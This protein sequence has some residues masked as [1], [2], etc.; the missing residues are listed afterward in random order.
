MK[1]TGR[2]LQVDKGQSAVAPQK[3]QCPGPRNRG[4]RR[5]MLD[6]QHGCRG[7]GDGNRRGPLARGLQTEAGA[8]P[9][10]AIRPAKRRAP[11]REPSACTEAVR[12]DPQPMATEMQRGW[13]IR[14]PVPAH[15]SVGE[16]G[17]GRVIRSWPVGC[18][19]GSSP[20]GAVLAGV[21]LRIRS[22]ALTFSKGMYGAIL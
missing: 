11:A 4:Q 14:C 15:M 1:P 19:E 17:P 7:A 10:A 13:K 22:K 21:P 6:R 9:A 12:D 16:T 2:R 5:S 20:S 3:I 8:S 18:L